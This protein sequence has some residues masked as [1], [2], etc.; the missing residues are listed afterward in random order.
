MAGFSE[1]I[2][3]FDKIRD[4]MR[5]FYIYGFRKRGD[6]DAKS[7]R[8]YDNEKRRI[9][10][11]LGEYIR[12]N[13]DAEGKRTYVALNSA[14]VSANPLHAAWK[15]K[16]FTDSDILLHFALLDTLRDGSAKHVPQLTEEVS[17]LM[18]T[19][20]DAQTVRGKCREYERQGIL[21]SEKQGRS[22]LYRIVPDALPLVLNDAV[23]FFSEVA[24]L[25]EIGSFLMDSAGIE[26]SLFR[27]KHHFIVHTLEDQVLFDILAAMREKRSVCLHNF[28]SRKHQEYETVGVPV[29]ILSS[30]VTGRRYVCIVQNGEKQTVVTRRLDY[31]RRITPLAVDTAYDEKAARVEAT[32]P[33]VWGVSFGYGQLDWLKMTLRIDEQREGYVLS[34]LK[35]EGRGGTVEKIEENTF[36]YFIEL[37]D[38]GEIMSWVKSFTG[39]ILA[40]E[41][42]DAAT[43]YRFH[44]DMRRMQKHYLPKEEAAD[45]TVQ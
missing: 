44:H 42:S 36:Q 18:E 7:A 13:Y 15:A 25:G 22:L 39:R 23:T 33:H 8:T 41:G 27:F 24:P 34:R 21:Q 28:S 3:N 31:I 12:W 5:D 11:Y 45:G 19:T 6:F 29:K 16:T 38:T 40:L 26:N 2:R 37:F 9:E 43:L 4:F 10:S 14:Q 30:T 32:L 1:L 17:L 20:F 35:R